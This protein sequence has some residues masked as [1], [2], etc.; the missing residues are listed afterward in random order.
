M[1][2]KTA[3]VPASVVGAAWFAFGPQAGLTFLPWAPAQKLDEVD[4]NSSEVNAASLDG[5][6]TLA[7]D[8]RSLYMASGPPACR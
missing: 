5:C 3:T 4:G 2:L 6:P 8:G 1:R 7:R